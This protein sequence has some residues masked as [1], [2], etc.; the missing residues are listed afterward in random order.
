MDEHAHQITK[1]TSWP[2]ILDALIKK[3]RRGLYSKKL[4]LV[5]VPKDEQPRDDE[6]IEG[7]R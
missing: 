2:D 4:G 3:G 5:N 6:V 1:P 7:R